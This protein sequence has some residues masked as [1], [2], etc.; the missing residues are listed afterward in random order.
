[1]TEQSFSKFKYSTHK[2]FISYSFCSTAYCY[3]CF[4]IP[5]TCSCTSATPFTSTPHYFSSTTFTSYT[6]PANLYYVCSFDY[7]FFFLFPFYKRHSYS[8]WKTR[9]GAL[10]FGGPCTY[11]ECKPS[12]PY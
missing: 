7:S 2:F 9:L 8:Y 11:P 3:S 12:W 6:T 10:A 5:S 4:S 1:M